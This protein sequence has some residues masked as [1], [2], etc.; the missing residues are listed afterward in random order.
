MVCIDAPKAADRA[1]E[2]GVQ[3]G[4]DGAPNGLS[5]PRLGPVAEEHAWAERDE[6]GVSDGL[7][8]GLGLALDL[9]VKAAGFGARADRRD[10]PKHLGAALARPPGERHD[11]VEIDRAKRSLGAGLFNGRAERTKGHARGDGVGRRE[12][13]QFEDERLDLGARALGSAPSD[14]DDALDVGVVV[15]VSEAETADEAGRPGD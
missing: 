2:E 15:E 12:L 1:E 4:H 7:D 13:L 10:E 3:R 6:G 14:R 11:S 8:R 5:R 9:H